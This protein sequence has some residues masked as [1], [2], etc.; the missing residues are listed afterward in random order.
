MFRYFADSAEKAG[1]G[2]ANSSAKL[3]SEFSH[4]I[5]PLCRLESSDS[6]LLHTQ[7]NTRVKPLCIQSYA[8]VVGVPLYREVACSCSDHVY[9]EEDKK[10]LFL[11][12]S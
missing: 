8:V 9:L 5:T 11:C 6:T 4:E 7:T 10:V 2:L 1:Q 12:V 3:G